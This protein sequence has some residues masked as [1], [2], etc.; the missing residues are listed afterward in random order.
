MANIGPLP[1]PERPARQRLV[2][3][4]LALVITA[5]LLTLALR[6]GSWGYDTRSGLL[7]ERRLRNLVEKKPSIEQAT[8]A[9]QAEHMTPGPASGKE[10]PEGRCTA[11]RAFAGKGYR[12]V[13]CVD[14]TGVVSDARYL[15]G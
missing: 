6:L 4:A 2:I 13:L 7:H 5:G 15:P 12:Y 11:T 10:F 14:E 1:A 8:E 9:L 3:V